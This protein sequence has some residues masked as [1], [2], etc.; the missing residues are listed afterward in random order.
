MWGVREL[1]GE[2]ALVIKEERR[3]GMIECGSE[4]GK[5]DVAGVVAA[6]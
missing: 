1:E 3:E 2:S 5:A 4:K 6:S